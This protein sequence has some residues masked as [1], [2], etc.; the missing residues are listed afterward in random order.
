MPIGGWSS[1][2]NESPLPIGRGPFVT[3]QQNGD[4]ERAASER[5]RRRG[6]RCPGVLERRRAAR[7]TRRDRARSS[8]TVSMSPTL[9]RPA[10][11]TVCMLLR[12][13][14]RAV[15]DP[16]GWS[17]IRLKERYMH[18]TEELRRDVADQLNGYFCNPN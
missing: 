14:D 4:D 8:R 11:L 18:V 12:V 7:R 13:S 16:M 3:G 6:R 10:S 17:S 1:V 15:Q 9:C 2:A 5:V